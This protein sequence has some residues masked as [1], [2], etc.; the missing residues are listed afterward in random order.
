M[1]QKN[2]LVIGGIGVGLYLL[3]K[4]L[5]QTCPTQT[6]PSSLCS[7]YAQVS[8]IFGGTAAAPAAP[9]PPTITGST[10]PV[11]V[12]PPLVTVTSPFPTAPPAQIAPPA[13]PPAAT[14][15]IVGQVTPNIN[16]SLSADV[17][18]NGQPMNLTIIPANASNSSG[19]AWNTQG[20]DIT[21]QL[22]SMG[23]N[24]PAVAKQ[25]QAGYA[26][27]TPAIPLQTSGLR[28]PVTFRPLVAGNPLNLAGIND[29][30]EYDLAYPYVFGKSSLSGVA[31]DGAFA[32]S[33]VPATM[34]HQGPRYGFRRGA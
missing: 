6:T 17:L 27:S 30:P 7:A 5:Q 15:T 9:A 32:H 20:Q 2:I 18:V 33:R 23:V 8:S 11:G 34:I 4:Y 21:G 1:N 22:L 26:S 10:A 28:P 19:A 31:G 24:I 25:F 3:Y 29:Y 13:P 16:N 14:V 12:P